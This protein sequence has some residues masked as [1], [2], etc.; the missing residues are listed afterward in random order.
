MP[1]LEGQSPA[2]EGL[3]AEQGIDVERGQGVG[4]LLGHGLDLDAAVA[5]EHHQG[6]LRPAVEDDR[7]VVLLGDLHGRAD[8]Q[9]ADDGAL[10]LHVEDRRRVL[11]DLRRVAG[12]LDPAG[13][14]SPAGAD[15]GLD[16]TG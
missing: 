14:A 8:P 9:L 3:E 13:L 12:Q 1:G 5:R 4:I 6:G 11:A 15:L 16:D 7:R 10:D 2:V